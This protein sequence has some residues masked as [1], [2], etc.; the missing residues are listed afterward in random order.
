MVGCGSLRW[1]VSVP[2]DSAR[3]NTCPL[4]F[5]RRPVA[6]SAVL[7][8][9][10]WLRSVR[11]VLAQ[12]LVCP[13]ASLAVLTLR[14]SDGVFSGAQRGAVCIIVDASVVYRAVI[15]VLCSSAVYGVE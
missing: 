9:G 11:R 8:R 12:C 10:F 5:S 3:S 14:L 15:L 6:S 13:C 7:C 4:V 2:F 1:V